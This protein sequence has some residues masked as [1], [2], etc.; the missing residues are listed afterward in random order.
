MQSILTCRC[1]SEAIIHSIK[2]P[3]WQYLMY[4]DIMLYFYWYTTFRPFETVQ[5]YPFEMLSKGP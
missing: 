4:I 5:H 2:L 3:D 1:D